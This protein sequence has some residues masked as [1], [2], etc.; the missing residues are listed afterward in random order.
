MN[1][2]AKS[3]I[4][5]V[6]TMSASAVMAEDILSY[7][8]CGKMT[9]TEVVAIAAKLQKSEMLMLEA[10]WMGN[11]NAYV[12][13]LNELVSKN[14]NPLPKDLADFVNDISARS[15]NCGYA[16]GNLASIRTSKMNKRPT[17]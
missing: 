6:L 3:F 5:L 7:L 9:D 17:R 14:L 8:D 12:Q 15:L 4:C 13:T 11:E 16:A 10:A 1:I 2:F